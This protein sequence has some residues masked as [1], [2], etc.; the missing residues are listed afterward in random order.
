MAEL[1]GLI[2]MRRH[3]VEQKQKFLAELYNQA[4]QLAGQKNT[5]LTQF[6]EEQAKMSQMNDELG[7]GPGMNY[8]GA[9][10]DAVHERVAEIEEQIEK[11]DGRIEVAR[12]DMR[13]AFAELKKVEITADKR[14]AEEDKEIA[15]KE[16]AELDEIAIE[17]YRRK[18]LEDG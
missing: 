3:S 16:S 15:D 10:S 14:K 5:L 1:D 7:M 6:E 9:Y 12:E 13:R 17:G 11:L 4:D 2:R 8:F 18:V